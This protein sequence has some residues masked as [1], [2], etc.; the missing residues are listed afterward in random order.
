MTRFGEILPLWQNFTSLWQNVDGLFLIWQNVDGL[1]LIWQNV[2]PIL[3][4]LLDYWAHFHCYK[5][6]NIEK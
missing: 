5:W 4:N 2:D 6:P 3:A 1:F